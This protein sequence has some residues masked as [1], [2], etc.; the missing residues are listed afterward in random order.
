MKIST[1]L[2]ILLLVSIP[3]K[4]QFQNNHAKD[5]ARMV[6][7]HLVVMDE[8][9]SLII[10]L[11]INSNVSI[12][13]LT[14]LLNEPQMYRQIELTGRKSLWEKDEEL[15]KLNKPVIRRTFKG[16]KQ[17]GTVDGA[18]YVEFIISQHYTI[19]SISF[20]LNYITGFESE[21]NMISHWKRDNNGFYNSV[22]R[23]A[24]THVKVS[25]GKDTLTIIEK[26][27]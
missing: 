26:N 23:V 12:E 17:N 4:A 2:A 27:E 18:G 15:R 13:A 25:Y 16:E 24:N 7:D 1:I 9:I 6:E 20:G 3:V 22:F 10:P 11:I 21:I 8:G 19:S 5:F 14:E